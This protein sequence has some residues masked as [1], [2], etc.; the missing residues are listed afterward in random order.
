M[1][2]SGSADQRAERTENLTWLSSLEPRILYDDISAQ[3]VLRTEKYQDWLDGI[4]GGEPDN[5]DLFCNGD[6]GVGKFYIMQESIPPTR[7]KCC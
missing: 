5:S 7:Q 6:P 1:N 4:R 3:R 2:G